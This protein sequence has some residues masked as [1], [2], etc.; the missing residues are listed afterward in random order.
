MS[1]RDRLLARRLPPSRV[2]LRVD[3]SPEADRAYELLGDAERAVHFAEAAGSGVDVARSQLAAARE[4]VGEYAE[5]LTISTLPA[6][7]YEQL[8]V[9]HPPTAEQR[10]TGAAWNTTTFVP[11]LLAACVDVDE[12]DPMTAEDWAAFSSTPNQAAAGE[13]TAL[14]NACLTANYRTLDEHVGKGSGVTRS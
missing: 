11:A 8:L 2:Q 9:E 12:D 7:Q 4:A 6:D 14:F 13:L 3:F 1:K 5:V 10:T